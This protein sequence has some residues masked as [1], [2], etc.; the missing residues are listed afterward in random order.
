MELNFIGL[1]VDQGETE[2][3]RSLTLVFSFLLIII[4]LFSTMVRAGVEMLTLI[5]FEDRKAWIYS[6]M[7]IVELSSEI[8]IIPKKVH[9]QQCIGAGG[10][11][12]VYRATI[13]PAGRESYETAVKIPHQSQSEDPYGLRSEALIFSMLDHTN[14]LRYSF[15]VISSVLTGFSGCLALS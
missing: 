1:I 12:K 4:E 11:G 6:Q 8:I 2:S 14:I 3:F 5:R 7:T 15:Y 10:F 9:L 13:Y